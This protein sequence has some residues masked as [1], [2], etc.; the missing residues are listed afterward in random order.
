[1][2]CSSSHYPAAICIRYLPLDEN[3]VPLSRGVVAIIGGVRASRMP[4]PAH[5]NFTAS[6][7]QPWLEGV[8]QPMVSPDGVMHDEI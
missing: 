3:D 5:L 2:Q 7:L 8:M 6:E 1:M 4:F